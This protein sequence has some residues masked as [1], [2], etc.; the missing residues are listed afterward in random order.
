[1][2][3]N[4]FANTPKVTHDFVVGNSQYSKTIRFQK[5]GSFCVFFNFCW[6]KMLRTVQFDDQFCLGAVK[7]RNISTQNLLS[8]K[9]YR[10]ASEKIIPKMSLF[11]CHIF[12]KFL[13]KGY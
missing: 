7:I 10:I 8:G 9:F 13:G 5:S 2:L 12:A 4:I 11:L 6:L 3:V 1:M